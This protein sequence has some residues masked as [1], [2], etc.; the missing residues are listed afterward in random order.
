MLTVP[1]EKKGR[2][3]TKEV[4]IESGM[5]WRNNHWRTIQ[6]AYAKS[7]FFEHYRDDL[8]QVIYL[9][10]SWLV[11]LD[12]SSL[13]F[14]LRNLGLTSRIELSTSY[15][16][17]AKPGVLDLRAR[18]SDKNPDAVSAFYHVTPYYQVFGNTF[19]S[20]L[21]AI[22]LLCCEGPNAPAILSSSTPR[23]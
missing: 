21:S 6:S 12:A 7:P 4:R 19:V 8:Y 5:R 1:L 3:A 17:V 23:I 2:I 13:S 14:C 9:P 11:E 22:D 10:T 18:I 16:E 20:N 15:E